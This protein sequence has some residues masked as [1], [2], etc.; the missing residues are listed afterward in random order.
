MASK[1]AANEA[2]SIGMAIFHQPNT[3]RVKIV[4]QAGILSVIPH[5]HWLHWT[6]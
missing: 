4:C 3:S 6:I 1:M 5:H 2:Y